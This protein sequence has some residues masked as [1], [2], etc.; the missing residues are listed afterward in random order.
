MIGWHPAFVAARLRLPIG[1]LRLIVD[2]VACD[3]ESSVGVEWHV[4][5]ADGR[6]F[7]LGR[8]LSMATMDQ[9]GK[10]LRVVDIC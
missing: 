2:E 8:G 3:G 4:E 6:A 7:P 5:F 1:G 10:L 9:H